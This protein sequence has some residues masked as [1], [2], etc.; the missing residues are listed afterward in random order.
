VSEKESPRRGSEIDDAVIATL[1][2]GHREFLRYLSARTASFADAEDILQDFYL[3]VVRSS[4]TIKA[5]GALR[6]WLA[7]VLRR[8]LADY[9]RK[10]SVRRAALQRLEEVEGPT[11]LI[12][13]AA[14][15]A[16][17]RCL[18]RILPTLRPDYSRIIWQ[19]DLLGQ[20]RNKVAEGF[21]I[22]ANNLGVRVHRAR[23]ALR[24]AL[25]RLCT[26]CPTHGFLNCACDEARW[27]I[28]SKS[29]RQ[30]R[31]TATVMTRSAV[32]LKGKKGD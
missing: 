9:Y 18:Y 29:S 21:G 3:K 14:E 1:R 5:P 7:Q 12:D 11:V 25:E 32:R 6:G 23:R 24:A 27:S 26:T 15:Q 30:R 4:R 8:T 16:V 20:P 17:C 10:A 19:V 28:A 31:Q 13:D 2:E 22:S